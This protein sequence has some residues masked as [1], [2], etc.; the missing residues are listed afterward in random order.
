MGMKMT[1]HEQL[2]F[3]RKQQG[4]SQEQLGFKVGVSSQTVSKWELGE[5]I[6]ELEKLIQLSDIFGVSLDDLTGH[7]PAYSTAFYNRP[8]QNAM[9]YSLCHY[10]YKSKCSIAGLPLIHINCGRGMHKA[11]GILAI[12][13]LAQGL[14]A[15][16]GLSFGLLSIG[17]L[18]LGLLSLGGLSLGLLISLGGLSIGTL[19]F[20]GC[21]IGIFSI[22]GLA[23]GVYSLGGGAIA[24]QIAAGGYANAPI[25]IGDLAK[26]QITFDVHQ[27]ISEYAIQNAILEKYPKTPEIIVDFFNSIK[28]LNFSVKY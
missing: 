26:G 7:Q 10:E 16:G 19:S 27:A 25:A 17:G 5:T 15:I 4:L 24:S 21:A 12:G 22:G 20:G 6:P 13:N 18:S 11:K 1:F 8:Y 14:V 9:V 3:L 28:N 23:I 2:I